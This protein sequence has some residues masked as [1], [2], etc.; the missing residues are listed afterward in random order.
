MR[1]A[2]AAL[3]FFP[4]DVL[5]KYPVLQVVAAGPNVFLLSAI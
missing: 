2:G 4:E 3:Q 1:V 5:L